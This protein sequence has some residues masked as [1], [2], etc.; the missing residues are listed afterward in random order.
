MKPLISDARKKIYSKFNPE[1]EQIL[2]DLL[3]INNDYK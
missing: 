3:F 2:N 1:Q